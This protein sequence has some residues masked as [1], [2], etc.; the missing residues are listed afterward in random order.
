MGLVV[1]LLRLGMVFLNVYETFKTLKMPPPS[2]RNGGQ[3][4]VR[5]LSQRK[6]DMKGCLTIWIV[7]CCFTT[8]ERLIE[9]IVSLFIPFYDEFK[10]LAILFLILTRARS[11]EPI[12]LHVIR[13]AL[14][15]HAPT[16]DMFLDLACMFGD[17]IYLLV[18][19]PYRRAQAWWNGQ[20][21]DAGVDKAKPEIIRIDTSVGNFPKHGSEQSQDAVTHPYYG[22]VD[23]LKYPAFPS[24]Y[25]PTPSVTQPKFLPPPVK[26]PYVP[27]IPEEGDD[28]DQ[29]HHHSR[30]A[31]SS[32]KHT[33]RNGGYS[34]RRRYDHYEDQDDSDVEVDEDLDIT[35]QSPMAPRG[36][37]FYD[38]SSIISSALNSARSHATGLSTIYT[39][40]SFYTRPS[41]PES[42]SSSEYPANGRRRQT[43]RTTPPRPSK[44]RP[45]PRQQGVPPHDARIKKVVPRQPPPPRVN[46]EVIKLANSDEEEIEDESADEGKRPSSTK[47]RR[48]VP[49]SR[50]LLSAR[51]S[52]ARMLQRAPQVAMTRAATMRMKSNLAQLHSQPTTLTRVDSSATASSSSSG[53]AS[54]RY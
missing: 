12:F 8:Y 6:R 14:K 51:A 29:P 9:R 17:I 24:A 42:A 33:R 25:P 28:D 4:S 19:H 23:D 10:S 13:P 15:P 45:A 5:A 18:T 48:I 32:P 44:A 3:P 38:D 11:A 47:R 30:R 34:N 36:R 35:L 27:T 54:R 22:A 31:S 20:V 39:P 50:A 43:N 40:S 53:P 49:N 1:P 41:S 46:G 21:F 7:W 16:L 52:R 26:A 37:S 2:A